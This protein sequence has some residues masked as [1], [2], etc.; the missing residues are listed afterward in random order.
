MKNIFY[1]TM[2]ILFSQS[3]FSQINDCAECDTK[4]YSY[5]DINHLSLLELKI[6][7]NEIFARHQYVFKDSR[8]SDYFLENYDWYKPDYESENNIE[9]NTI[10]K[11]NVNLLL[12]YENKKEDLK[13]TIIKELKKIKRAQATNDTIIINRLVNKVVNKNQKEYSND[14]KSELKDI[15][16][17]INIDQINWYNEKGLFKVTTDDGHFIKETTIKIHGDSIILSYAYMGYSE[18]LSDETAFKFGSTFYSE[19][20]YAS[21]YTFKIIDNEL[22]LIE[23]LAAG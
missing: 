14:I 17:V 21:W 8:L 7:R 23:H 12:K 13:T 10:E 2:I 20:E 15:L 1:L 19:N 22:V 6:L 16:S 4:T 3:S 11:Q 18:L 9:L 5:E